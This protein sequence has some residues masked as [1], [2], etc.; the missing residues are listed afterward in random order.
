MVFEIQLIVRKRF[1]RALRAGGEAREEALV[2][3]RGREVLEFLLGDGWDLGHGWDV[4]LR[5]GVDF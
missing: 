5:V 3:P 1:G 4:D 2:K